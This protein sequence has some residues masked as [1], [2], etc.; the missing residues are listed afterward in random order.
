MAQEWC[1]AYG[2]L[3]SAQATALYQKIG[4]KKKQTQSP[5]KCKQSISKPV[6]AENKPKRRKKVIDDDDDDNDVIDTG[7]NISKF[8]KFKLILINIG[9]E[10]SGVWEGQ[11]RSGI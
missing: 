11:G 3:D 9:F 1:L 10:E 2:I 4:N 7:R 5:A 8:L 6:P